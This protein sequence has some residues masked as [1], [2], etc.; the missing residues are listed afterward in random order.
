MRDS[1]GVKLWFGSEP[2][3]RPLEVNV[4]L[5]AQIRIPPRVYFDEC[6]ACRVNAAGVAVAWRNH[7]HR[8][9]RD[10]WS[11]RYDAAGRRLPDFGR[12]S[13]HEPQIFRLLEEPIKM[14][15]GETLLLHCEYDARQEC[16]PSLRR[17]PP[18]TTI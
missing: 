8:L 5:S 7:A 18:H 9:G 10:I 6:V 11:E 12:K 15:A 4:M 2:P 1:S 13:A 14:S 16:A 3:A 17:F